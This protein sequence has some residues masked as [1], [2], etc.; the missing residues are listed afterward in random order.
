MQPEAKRVL[1]KQACLI[2]IGN[3]CVEQQLRAYIASDMGGLLSQVINMFE[4]D[5][6]TKPFDWVES[7]NKQL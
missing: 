3:L 7:T 5:V 2:F 4:T 6:K 1:L